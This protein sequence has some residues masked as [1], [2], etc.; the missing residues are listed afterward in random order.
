MEPPSEPP[1]NLQNSPSGTS[2]INFEAV[3][4]PAQ[5]KLRAPETILHFGSSSSELLFF[6]VNTG[7]YL[8]CLL[9]HRR[10]LSE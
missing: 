3:P 5:F 2:G 4:G 8:N 1:R 7:R 9:G 6:D 10:V